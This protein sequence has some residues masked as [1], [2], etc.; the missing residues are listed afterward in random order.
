MRGNLRLE[1]IT[2]LDYLEINARPA[3]EFGV[4]YREAHQ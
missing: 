3:A 4:G 1:M 2:D